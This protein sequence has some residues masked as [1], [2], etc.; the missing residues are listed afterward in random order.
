[1]RRPNSSELTTWPNE[2]QQAVQAKVH[3]S[4]QQV[5]ELTDGYACRFPADPAS[6]LLLAEFIDLERRS[7]PDLSICLDVITEHGPAWLQLTGP[8]GTKGHLRVALRL[9]ADL[10]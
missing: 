3:R 4:I 10:L 9:G 1:M 7:L 6:L 2:W 5:C 8:P